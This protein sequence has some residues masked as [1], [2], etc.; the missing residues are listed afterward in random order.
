ME[1][2]NPLG[3]FLNQ[4]AI[5]DRVLERLTKDVKTVLKVADEYTI[6]TDITVPNTPDGLEISFH[7]ETQDLAFEKPE[8]AETPVQKRIKQLKVEDRLKQWEVRLGVSD[9]AL[10]NKGTSAQNLMNAT[11]AGKAF[12]RAMNAEGLTN[13]YAALAGTPVGVAWNLAT[14]AQIEMDIANR[15]DALDDEGF[16]GNKILMNRLQVARLNHTLNVVMFGGQGIKVSEWLS[17][18]HQLE[19]TRVKRINYKN[20]NGTLINL[21][22]PTGQVLIFE[23]EAYSVFTQ[24]PM[25]TE[26]VRKPEIGGWVAYMRKKFK[27]T[28]VQTEACQKL[29]GINL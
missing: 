4:D 20:N 8:L 21:F 9:E 3:I 17:D 10:E 2:K 18:N 29:I 12:A 11:S 25:T 28:P 27:T 16:T 13:M 7:T 19:L 26:V 1:Q 15:L 14:N 23:K 24:N 5:A 22:N 6:I